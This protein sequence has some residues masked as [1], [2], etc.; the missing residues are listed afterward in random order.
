MADER[1]FV[2]TARRWQLLY[3]LEVILLVSVLAA[4]FIVEY[5]LGVR[6]RRGTL[7]GGFLLVFGWWFAIKPTRRKFA[8][9]CHQAG[10]QAELSR[11][12]AN[13]SAVEPSTLDIGWDR[14]LGLDPVRY[15]CEWDW[16]VQGEAQ[17]IPFQVGRFTLR[18]ESEKQPVIKNGLWIQLKCSGNKDADWRHLRSGVSFRRGPALPVLAETLKPEEGQALREIDKQTLQDCGFGFDELLVRNQNDRMILVIKEKPLRDQPVLRKPD[19]TKDSEGERC[20]RLIRAAAGSI[21]SLKI[22]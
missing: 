9:V 7:A 13:V 5:R 1:R 8:G 2:R 10:F 17:G 19:L 11:Q 21:K 22:R 6:R 3:W 4:D 15:R 16:A 18:R 14:Q 20:A 12:F